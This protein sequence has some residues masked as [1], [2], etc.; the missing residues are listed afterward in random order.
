[1]KTLCALLMIAALLF[2][3]PSSF[4]LD[5]E[6][7]LT[8]EELYGTTWCDRLSLASE[9][10]EISERITASLGACFLRDEPIWRA[11][12]APGPRPRCHSHFTA[13]RG[14]RTS[15]VSRAA[16]AGTARTRQ[17]VDR[18]AF[19]TSIYARRAG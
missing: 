4:G 17:E 10:P 13:G 2:S 12:A 19:R 1:M 15:G 11:L 6:P 9:D 5:T 3:G 8:K 16:G 7:Q 14:G 18:D